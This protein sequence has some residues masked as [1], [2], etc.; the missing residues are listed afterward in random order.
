MKIL[1]ICT[2]NT[3]RSLMA[4]AYAKKLINER[5]LTGIE[6][7][8]CGTYASPKYP[9]PETVSS[10]LNDEGIDVSSHVSTPVTKELVERS[11]LIFVME[12]LHLSDI[13]SLYPSIKDKIHL[14]K[15]YA[16]VDSE[17]S[18]EI[19]DPIGQPEQTYRLCLDEIKRC[20]KKIFEKL[21]PHT[22]Y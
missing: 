2:G 8:S 1:F 9:I 11:D 20:L 15:K 12:K 18:G 22:N 14:L 4:E 21:Y 19:Q 3:C 6:V 7:S 17:P 13:V 16:G 10:L 5:G